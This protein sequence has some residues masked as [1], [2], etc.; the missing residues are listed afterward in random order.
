MDIWEAN[1]ISNALTPHNCKAPGL[2][3]CE[4]LDCGDGADRYKSIC[5]KDGCDFNPYRQGNTTYYGEGKTVD[6]SK[7]MTVVTQF[8]TDDGTD[9]GKLKE[10]RRKFIQ[11]GN[12]FEMP[13]NNIEGI[14]AFDSVS[15]EF[16]TQQKTTFGDNNQ[17]GGMGGI[18]TMGDAIGRGMVLA[19]SIWDD[20]AAR[21]LWLDSTY[22]TDSTKLGAA[23][24]EC[25][26]TSGDPKDVEVN[27]ADSTVT[28]SNIKIGELDSTYSA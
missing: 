11:D 20:H 17:F 2:V 18:A 28:Y 24:G 13:K 7:K 1:S 26:T 4:G 19:M 3:R 15:D 27:N 8:I 12:V 21:M 22:P 10:I 14:D 9:T 5:D 6:T 16:C 25:P 23:R